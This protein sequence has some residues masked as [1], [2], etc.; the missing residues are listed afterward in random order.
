MQT[1]IKLA[2]SLIIILICIQV[3]KRFP[4]LAGLI[5]VMPI[6]S[7]IVLIWLHTDN[8]GDPNLIPNYIKGVLWG[9]VPSFFFYLTALLCFK[10]HLPFAISLGA[11]FGVW[12]VSALL[13]HWLLLK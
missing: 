8:S 10:R 7:L 4:S 5:V 1:I 2:V 13:F 6:T 9:L 11:G 3:G 12:L